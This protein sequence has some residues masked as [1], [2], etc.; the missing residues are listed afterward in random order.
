VQNINAALSAAACGDTI[1]I[2]AGASASITGPGQSITYA[3]TCPPGQ[4]ITVTTTKPDWLPVPPNRILPSYRP[5]LPAISL[6]G[7]IGSGAVVSIGS[8][9]PV[10]SGLK[11]VGI[12]FLQNSGYSITSPG[13]AYSYWLNIGPVGTVPTDSP[14][15]FPDNIT[16]D[17]TL[18]YGTYE[19]DKSFASVGYLNTRSFNFINSYVGGINGLTATVYNGYVDTTVLRSG[20]GAQ[21]LTITN[22]FFCCGWTE[23]ML[24]GGNPKNS[25]LGQPQGSQI[26]FT[27]N[28]TVNALRFMPGTNVSIPNRPAIKNCFEMKEGSNSVFRYNTCYNSWANDYSQWFGAKMAHYLES[29][30]RSFYNASSTASLSSGANGPNSRVT[31]RGANSN[32]WL[33]ARGGIVIGL[34]KIASPVEGFYF[35]N[36]EW[37]YH[38]VINVVSTS[39]NFVLDVDQ[40]YTNTY[41]TA[42]TPYM[43]VANPWTTFSNVTIENNVFRDVA[44]ALEVDGG[45]TSD[46]CVTQ[47]TCMNNLIFRNNLQ[48]ISNPQANFGAVS[49]QPSLIKATYGSNQSLLTH[50]QTVIMPSAH[51][52]A[53]GLNSVFA[54]NFGNARTYTGLQVTSNAGGPTAFGGPLGSDLVA[55]TTPDLIWANNSYLGTSS[56]ENGASHYHLV[57]SGGRNCTGNVFDNQ[58]S[59]NLDYHYR[60]AAANDFALIADAVAVCGATG[61]SPIQITTCNPHQFLRGQPVR[62]QGVGGVAAANG[63]YNLCTTGGMI[64]ATHF[65][66]CTSTNDPIGGSGQYTGGGTVVFAN[67]QGG[68]DGTDVGV[69]PE[70]SPLLRYLSVSPMAHSALIRWLMPSA[71]TSV[72]C[73]A[74]VSAN[75]GLLNDDSDYTVIDALRPDYFMRADS[76]QVN[77][78]ATQSRDGRLRWFQVGDPS[79]RIGDDG[80]SHDLS[81]ASGTTYYYRIFCGGAMERGSFT[82]NASDS[83]NSSITVTA[84]AT[85]SGASQVRVRYGVQ[86]NSLTTGAPVPC[87]T[88]CSLTIPATSGRPL[89]YYLDELDVNGNVVSP[90][91]APRVVAMP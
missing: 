37:E 71:F 35:N 10:P 88:G 73:Q 31:I 65:P 87:V 9:S 43:T 28:V 5:L 83:G 20:D 72:G 34:P 7:P 30:P 8:R 51:P 64:D 57:C 84:R 12:A 76:D 25:F 68:F 33:L 75:S 39:P 86:A 82:T 24:T 80:Q 74:E 48:L 26:T 90:V 16:F 67:W 44:T 17:R 14:S 46:Y 49:I 21:P 27:N 85:A 77:P 79:T 56:N 60:N 19:P 81:L 23:G 62:I 55:N 91:T 61:S 69:N 70:F 22:N 63:I 52:S 4:E 3:K 53:Q 32:T 58:S 15:L 11:F 47:T 2:Q 89:I 6:D 45:D 36:G 50:N 59:M 13:A 38:K 66:V 40:P 41:G 78:L 42:N 1:Q 29:A 18:F 54:F